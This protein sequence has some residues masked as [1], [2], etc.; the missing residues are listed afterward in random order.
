MPAYVIALNILVLV[1]V[2]GLVH[3]FWRF[4]NKP[5]RRQAIMLFVAIGLFVMLACV[6]ATSIA[7]LCSDPDGSMACGRLWFDRRP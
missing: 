1:S 6:T 3:A 2:T 4:L 7:G 5:T